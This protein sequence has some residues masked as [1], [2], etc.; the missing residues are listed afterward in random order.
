M[1]F[2]SNQELVGYLKHEG[3]LNGKL[4]EAF[5]EMDRRNFIPKNLKKYAYWDSALPLFEG[6]TISQPTTVAFMLSLL[7]V[8][9]GNKILDVGAGSGWVSALLAYLVGEGGCVYAFEINKAVGLFGLNNLKKLNLKNVRYFIEDA[10]RGWREFAPYNRIYSGA[11]FKKIPGGL[12]D[13]L[14][15]EGVLVAPTQDGNIRKIKRINKNKFKEEIFPGFV[16]VPFIK[17]NP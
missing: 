1:N 10:S 7:D 11:G 9:K 13:L 12:R 16:F 17:N 2:Y 3:L 14:A 8:K 15:I 5:L 6:Q 4:E